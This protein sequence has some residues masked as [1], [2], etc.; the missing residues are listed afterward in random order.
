MIIIYL[1]GLRRAEKASTYAKIY[2]SMPISFK[3]NETQQRH[4]QKCKTGCL[5]GKSS[6]HLG[7]STV[8]LFGFDETVKISLY[9]NYHVSVAIINT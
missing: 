4:V 9:A 5:L 8:D 6:C 1:K 2:K 7:S 3:S